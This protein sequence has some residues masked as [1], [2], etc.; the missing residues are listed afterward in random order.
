MCVLNREIPSG[1]RKANIIPV[2]V[3]ATKSGRSLR[4][5]INNRYNPS[6]RTSGVA[7]TIMIDPQIMTTEQMLALPE[8]GMDRELISGRLREKPMT[9]RNR[10]HSR[11]ESKVVKAIEI[12]LDTRPAPRGEVLCGEAG[13]PPQ[14]QPRTRQS[15]LMLAYISAE[16]AL[17]TPETASLVEGPPILAVEILSPSDTHEDI[18]DKVADYLATGVVPGVRVIDPAFRTVTVYQPRQEPVLFNAGQSL[19]GGA[20]LPGFRAAVADLFA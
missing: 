6:D 4:G 17:A 14:T 18:S 20:H 11:T 15:A 2:N 13:F 10:R 1:C 16:L 7:M 19:D 9:R 8:D 5:S 12:W 3:P